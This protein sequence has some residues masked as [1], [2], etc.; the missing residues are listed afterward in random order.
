ML[1]NKHKDSLA[2]PISSGG[3]K[4]S[5]FSTDQNKLLGELKRFIPSKSPK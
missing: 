1:I 4:N 3:R 2:K 5:K